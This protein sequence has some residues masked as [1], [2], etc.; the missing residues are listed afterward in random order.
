[1]LVT[2]SD[3]L[4][5]GLLL[6]L[7]FFGAVLVALVAGISFHECCHAVVA[8]RLG[9]RTPRAMGR[10]SL[11]PL[12]HLEPVGTFFMLLVGFGWGKPVMVNPNRLRNGPE[13]GR[14][15]VAAAGP[16]SNLL[17]AAVASIPIN[18]DLAPWRSPFLIVRTSGWETADYAGLFLTSLVIFNVILAVFNLLPI[19]PL[20]GFAVAV[21]L[22][23]RDLGR[24]LA[25]LEPYGPAILMLLLILPFVSRGQVSVL[26]E[27]MSPLIN[28]LTELFSG[29]DARALG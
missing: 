5:E 19:A 23:P 16:L 11:N 26:H 18:L 22:L 2:Y 21:G 10:I 8:D 25:R 9:D 29:G 13:A 7:T 14:A 24:S 28:G 12:R 4:S 17:L 15:M 6:F 20:D 1:M 27:V 3:L